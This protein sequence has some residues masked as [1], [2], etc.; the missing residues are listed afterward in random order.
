MST[1]VT[2]NISDGTDTVGTEY[3]VNGSAK[4]WVNFDGTGTVA[5]RDG[6]NVASIT[7]NGEGHYTVNFT[8]A[9]VDASFAF[10]G[11]TKGVS[12]V[13]YGGP[14]GA[15]DDG[16]N[17]T[18]SVEITTPKAGVNSGGPFNSPEVNVIVT[19]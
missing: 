6:F 2:S 12:T 17:T 16:I 18:S 11:S 10:S 13:S 4:A 3:V 5:I 8:T 15:R 19:R 7:D 9:L 14:V 1:L